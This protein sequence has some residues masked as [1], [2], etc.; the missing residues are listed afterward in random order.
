[1]SS[2][3]A[4]FFHYVGQ[5][6]VRLVIGLVLIA[7]AA[8]VA[9]IP[10]RIIGAIVDDLNRGAE[11]GAIVQLALL[12]I[13]LAAVENVVRGFGRFNI[14]DS[15][16]RLEY[17]MRNDLFAHLERMHL[18][19][20]QHQ[21]IGDLMARLTNDLNAVRQMTGFGILMGSSTSLVVIFTVI[22]MLGVSVK[23]TLISL[24]LMPIAT[25]SFA[26]IGR[27][28]NQR[29]EQLQARFGDLS[30]KAQENFSGIRVVK[31]FSQEEAE[32]GS[33]ATVNRQYLDGAV[34]LAK[35]NGLIWPAMAFVLG[36]AVLSVLYVGGQDAIAGRLTIGQLIQFVAYLNL[37]SW[38]MIALG[39]VTNMFQQGWA[40]LRRLQEIFDATPAVDDPIDAVTTPIRG[41]VELRNVYF[42]YG[43]SIVLRD[44]SFHVPAG[45]SLAIVGQTGA[46]KSSLVNLIP[47][48]F[49]VQQ[50][51]VLIDGVNVMRYPLQ[52]LRRAVGY[53]PQETYLFSVPLADNVGFGAEEPL[54]AAQLDW[55]GDV[56]QLNKDVEDFPARFDT[57]IGERGVTLSGGQKQRTAI[58]RAVAK[59]PRVL[60]LDDALSAV[61]TYTEAEILR[62]LRGVMN[63]RT[64]IVVAHRISTVKDADEI[65]VLDDGR[66][67]ERGTHRELLERNGLYAQMYRRQLLE[68]ELEVDEEQEEHSKRVRAQDR[69][70]PFAAGPRMERLGG[71]GP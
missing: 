37:L 13:A 35:V 4:T 27:R 59:D 52:Q 3:R 8:F 68:E 44:V 60:I 15:S 38:P 33:F 14:I 28:V 17:R 5:S 45:G 56:S 48:L 32:I 69:D 9:V 62:R 19:Y 18:A 47:R 12:M 30:T 6:T 20:F 31:A 39:E 46:G 11:L 7:V 25:I 50:G 63:E 2:A 26:V 64:S 24:V 55:A 36:V 66:I 43:Q 67:A 1:V 54:T 42:A 34:D 23:L 29:F 70:E 21:R 65:L 57:M 53:V 40:S 41:D 71:D 10:P 22:S 58:A 61:D 16:R 49:D 51:E